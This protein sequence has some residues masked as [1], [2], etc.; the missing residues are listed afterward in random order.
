MVVDSEQNTLHDIKVH[1]RHVNCK[2]NF[3]FNLINTF[4][5]NTY[6]YH[7]Y[8][9]TINVFDNFDFIFILIIFDSTIYC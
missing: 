1:Y 4:H 5:K 9:Q 7:K 2:Y 3:N 6:L 8:N